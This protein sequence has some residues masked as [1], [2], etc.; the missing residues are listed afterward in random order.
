MS[1]FVGGGSLKPNFVAVES[2]IKVVFIMVEGFLVVGW[3]DAL[4][5]AGKFVLLA[6][7]VQVQ[8]HGCGDCEGLLFL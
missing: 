3:G 4:S 8:G 2:S 1:S 6:A 7:L 5:A